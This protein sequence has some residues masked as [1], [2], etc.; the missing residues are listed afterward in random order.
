MKFRYMLA[1]LFV[2][3]TASTVFADCKDMVGKRVRV[4]DIVENVEISDFGNNKGK[5]IYYFSFS[6]KDNLICGSKAL[7][8]FDR[9]GVIK[10]KVG[11]RLTAEGTL[12]LDRL[13]A[14]FTDTVSCSDK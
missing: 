13:Y 9:S 6:A 5:T 7:F 12:A 3:I 8:V 14:V 11:Q 1:C 4:S 10:C 2:L